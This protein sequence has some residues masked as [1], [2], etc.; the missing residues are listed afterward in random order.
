MGRNEKMRAVRNRH[1]Y[2]ASTLAVCMGL[3]KLA[4]WSKKDYMEFMSHLNA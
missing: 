4:K 2:I 1:Q 3:L